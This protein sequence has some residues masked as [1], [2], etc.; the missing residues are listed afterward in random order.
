MRQALQQM[1][2]KL[3]LSGK[4]KATTRSKKITKWGSLLVKA[5]IQQ[6][7]EIIYTH[8]ISNPVIVRGGQYKCRVF[9]THFNTHK[10]KR[11]SKHNTK[12]SHQENQRR[13]QKRKGRKKN[14]KNKSKTIK[15]MTIEIYI[16]I[17]TLNV[18]D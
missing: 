8:M 14:Y 1:L 17:I 9:E 16:L 15:K 6:R 3:L 18:M 12:D 7:W 5:N 13:E 2:K 11:E 10:K 4:E